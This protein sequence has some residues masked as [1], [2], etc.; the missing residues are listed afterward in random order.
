MTATDVL[1]ALLFLAFLAFAVTVGIR[2]GLRWEQTRQRIERDL[3]ELK[4]PSERRARES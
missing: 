2:F 1:D 3:A 4:T